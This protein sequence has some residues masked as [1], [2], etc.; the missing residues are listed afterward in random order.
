VDKSGVKPKQTY[1]TNFEE[2]HL[3]AFEY[4]KKWLDTIVRKG[5]A[6][7]FAVI[8]AGNSYCRLGGDIGGVKPDDP[9]ECL[10]EVVQPEVFAEDVLWTFSIADAV[11][12]YI[13]G[14]EG[15]RGQPMLR[16]DDAKFASALRDAFRK[17]ANDLDAK[18][19]GPVSK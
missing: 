9:T 2:W 13:E 4:P 18:I 7:A 12:N 16:G 15:G 11:A 14:H 19:E 1:T 8:A 17:L 10:V 6:E 5:V 3:D